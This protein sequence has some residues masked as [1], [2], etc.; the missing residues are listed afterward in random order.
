MELQD[1]FQVRS[2][3]IL[4]VEIKV[5]MHVVVTWCD[6]KKLHPFKSICVSKGEAI[7]LIYAYKQVVMEDSFLMA[8]AIAFFCD[9]LKIDRKGKKVDE[10]VAEIN[11]I[12]KK[13]ME[14]AEH[15]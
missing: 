11:T 14:E 6:T 3:V 10:V 7:G 1:Y 13:R 8:T 9:Y 2:K 4:G 12:A 15:E 5:E